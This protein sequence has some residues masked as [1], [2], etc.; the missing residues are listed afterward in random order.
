MMCTCILLLLLFDIMFKSDVI[1][2]LAL[3]NIYI[4]A[5]E[6]LMRSPY[7]QQSDMWSVGVIMFL[8]LA[9][10]LPFM[11]RTQKDL[12]RNI[13]MG[14]YEFE[15]ES[16]AH[17]SDQAKELVRQLLV[18]DPNRRLSSREALNSSWMRERGSMLAMNKLQHTS[19]RLAGFN[20]RM[21]LRGS[22]LA[23]TSVARMRMS[24][25]SMVESGRSLENKSS[26]SVGPSKRSSFL[27]EFQ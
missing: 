7:D 22:M 16:W 26:T 1:H 21:K 13:V 25:R 9:G 6:V 24:A 8:L 10:D 19:T 11:G 20:A 2:S 27:D 15:E 5:P 4:T 18:T 3:H 12:F 17:V 14:K 23:V